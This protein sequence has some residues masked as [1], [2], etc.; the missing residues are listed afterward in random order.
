MVSGAFGEERAV[1]N[2]DVIPDGD[3]VVVENSG[4]SSKRSEDSNW[5]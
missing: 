4:I 3:P 1:G 5:K 2:R